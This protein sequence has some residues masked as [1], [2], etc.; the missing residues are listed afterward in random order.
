M[1]EIIIF[2]FHNKKLLLPF[3]IAFFQILINILNACI[4]ENTKNQLL[5]MIDTAFSEIAIALIPLFNFYSFTPSN[6]NNTT[7]QKGNKFKKFLHFF[8]LCFIFGSYISLNIVKSSEAAKYIANKSLQ[9]PHNSD[10]SSFESLELIFIIIVSFVL[11]KYKYFRHH[12][13]ALII[14]II[15]SISIDLILGNFPEIKDR[16]V[17]FIFLNII[18]TIIDAIDYGYQKYMMDVL[19]HPFWSVSLTIGCMNLFIFGFFIL[20]CLVKG[21]EKSMEE[22]NMMFMNFYDY[23]DK[24]PVGIIIAKHILN[25]ILNIALNL[26]RSLTIYYFTPDYI[27]ISFTISR[28]TDIFMDTHQYEC[29]A[30][31][32][33]QLIT[34]MFYL[35]IFELNFCGLNT[36]T[37]KNILRREQQEMLL[38]DKMDR[39]SVSSSRSS[40]FSGIDITPDYLVY[41]RNSNSVVDIS[42]PKYEVVENSFELSDK[43]DDE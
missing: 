10:L 13:I 22:K 11:L 3:G 12:A 26:F 18:L 24:V 33:I 2:N 16:G 39:D 5:E 35:E 40:S 14:F 37:R 4:G 9:N 8:V 15:I 34:L 32:I 30:L 19:F 42:S 23:F 41:N 25:L 21:K 27:L 43:Y 1:G 38:Q 7:P 36:N 6:P 28:I 17:A 31:V 20:A 29:L